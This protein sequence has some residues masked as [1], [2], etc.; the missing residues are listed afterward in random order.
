MK[1]FKDRV[2]T[3]KAILQ[4]IEEHPTQYT[5]LIRTTLRDSTPWVAQSTIQWL[6]TESYVE[7]P[8]RGTYK[9]TEKGRRLLQAIAA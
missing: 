4:C 9:I 8:S 7:R 6:L 2:K 1:R 5:P 3:I